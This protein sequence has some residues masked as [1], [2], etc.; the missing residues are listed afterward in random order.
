MQQQVSAHAAFGAVA[1]DSLALWFA[2]R[3]LA[4]DGLGGDGGEFGHGPADASH[5]AVTYI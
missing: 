4:H 2:T 5:A 1:T 3:T